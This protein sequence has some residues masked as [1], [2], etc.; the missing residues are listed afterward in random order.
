[1]DG[2][3]SKFLSSFL[4]AFLFDDEEEEP[5]QNATDVIEV[6]DYKVEDITNDK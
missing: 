3:F 2:I 1:M 5:Q 4:D 6:T